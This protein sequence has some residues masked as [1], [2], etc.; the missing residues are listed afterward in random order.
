MYRRRA[1]LGSGRRH[2]GPTDQ[3]LVPIE[4]QVVLHQVDRPLA[5]HHPVRIVDAWRQ[6]HLVEQVARLVL[7]QVELHLQVGLVF[8]FEVPDASLA[9]SQV[10]RQII[11]Q[12]YLPA[13]A[14]C[15]RPNALVDLTGG[16]ERG[17]GGE[18]SRRQWYFRAA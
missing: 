18:E 10:H 5:N 14:A 15:D 3:L 2:V 9:V 13:G 8:V 1:G 11:V 17:G 7:P 6:V 16:G 12:L 4:R